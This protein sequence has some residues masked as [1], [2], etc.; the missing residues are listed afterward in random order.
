MVWFCGNAREVFKNQPTRRFLHG[1][2]IRGSMV[3]LWIFNRSGLYS[4]EKL[5]IHKDPRRFIRVMAGYTMMSDEELGMNTYIKE[6]EIS[7]YIMFKGE[8]KAKEE[9]LYL[10]GRPIAF[11]RAIIY[12]GTT[13]YRAKKQNSKRWEFVVK[14]S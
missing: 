8:D 9:K 10:E 11:Q 6:D 3:E 13:C 1:F 14:F 12:R 4:C 5:D 7:K 2:I